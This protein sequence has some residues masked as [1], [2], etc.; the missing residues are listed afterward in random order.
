MRLACG[1]STTG[2]LCSPRTRS[3]RERGQMQAHKPSER[4]SDPY[5]PGWGLERGERT[6]GR[7]PTGETNHPNAT[8]RRRRVAA[9]LM[10]DSVL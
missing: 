9:D 5:L 1:V 2:D 6:N 8:G 4:H 7:T 10:G 3:E